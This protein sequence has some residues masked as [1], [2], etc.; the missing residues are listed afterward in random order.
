MSS[1]VDLELNGGAADRSVVALTF[2]GRLFG[3]SGVAASDGTAGVWG[4]ARSVG[5][6]SSSSA[7]RAS[8]NTPCR[9]NLAAK[10]SSTRLASSAGRRFLTFRML[11]P[12]SAGHLPAAFPDEVRRDRCGVLG[13]QFSP[14]A[15]QWGASRRSNAL[16]I[17]SKEGK[18]RFEQLVHVW[19]DLDLMHARYI[20]LAR[21]NIEGKLPGYIELLH[22]SINQY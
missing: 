1:I 15:G 10:A 13:G 2:L 14:A 21:Y 7:D 17:G 6:E 16:L 18:L 4:G 9:A 19:L 3:R 20:K 12:G 11:S 8:G 5:A 22:V